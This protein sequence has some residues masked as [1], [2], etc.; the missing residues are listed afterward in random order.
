MDELIRAASRALSAGDALGAL[1]LVALR[2][3]A[4]ALALRGIA[5]A[6]LGNLDLANSVLRKAVSAFP[7]AQASARA[8]CVVALAEIAFASRDLNGDATTLDTAPSPL[9]THGALPN[10]PHRANT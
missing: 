1:N 4:S 2:A 8:R 3:D 7:T 10:P 5:I 9:A 6:Q